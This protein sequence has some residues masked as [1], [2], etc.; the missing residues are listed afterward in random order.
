[1][2]VRSCV[3]FYFAGTVL[4]FKVAGLV[5]HIW[6]EPY[7]YTAFDCISGDFPAKTSHVQTPCSCGDGQPYTHLTQTMGSCLPQLLRTLLGFMMPIMM[8]ISHIL[9][10]V[11]G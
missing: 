5:P 1:V 6:R 8:P 3:W 9:P 11:C 4:F 2:F 10:E 7:I